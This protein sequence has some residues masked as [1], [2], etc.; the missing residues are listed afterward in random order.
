M[1]VTDCHP[2]ILSRSTVGMNEDGAVMYIG[3]DSLALVQHTPLR[4]HLTLMSQKRTSGSQRQATKHNFKVLDLCTGSGVQALSVLASLER[5]D[6][7]A[8]ALCV[9]INERALRFTK[10]NSLL[11]G[12]EDRVHVIKADLMSGQIPDDSILSKT[13]EKP[14]NLLDFLLTSSPNNYPQIP[15]GPFDII[16]SNP[17]FVPTPSR[18]EDNNSDVISKRYGLF[19]S[20]GSSGEDVLQFV[21]SISSRVLR[22]DNGMLAIV[23]E[24][25]NPPLTS[26][27]SEGDLI[28]KNEILQKISNWWEGKFTLD[29]QEHVPTSRGK[30]LLYTNSIPISASTYAA[31]RADD[32]IEYPSWIRNLDD[33]GIHSVSP[34]LLYIKT[35]ESNARH[36]SQLKS[37]DVTF[38]LV[39]KDDELG[40]I[41]TPYNFKAVSYIAKEWETQ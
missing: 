21:V 15:R 38:R 30:G 10:F 5:V 2:T 32:A 6:P 11:N 18:A 24:F 28:R 20:G 25:M 35:C 26:N 13:S 4:H 40:S 9:D 22:K 7:K 19:S 29:E 36:D 31:R 39:P 41:W 34:G 16:L 33:Q 12:F 1:L 8:S 17:P 27:P 37:L 3:P 23:S 14:Q